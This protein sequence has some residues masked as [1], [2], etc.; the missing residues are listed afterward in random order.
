MDKLGYSI[1]Y[2]IPSTKSSEGFEY[3]KIANEEVLQRTG[4]RRLRD[5]AAERR[6][7]FAGHI[8]RLL[9]DRPAQHTVP[10]IGLQLGREKERIRTKKTWRTTFKLQRGSTTTWDQLV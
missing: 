3:H 7:L 5:I 1:D 10:W 4:Q 9:Q 8:I 2:Y 6:F